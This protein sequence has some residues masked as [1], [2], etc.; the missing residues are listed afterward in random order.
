M[1]GVVEDGVGGR[2]E[3]G[4]GGL[5]GAG[6]VVT[7]EAGEIAA[8]DLKADGVAF[9]ECVGGGPEV[10]GDFVDLIGIDEVG[11]FVGVAVAH[12]EDAVGEIFGEA[13]G[14]DVDEHGGEVGVHG[15]GF[16]IGLE[17]DGAGDLHVGVER[18]GGVDENVVAIF[19]GALISRAG[20][21]VNH[22]AAE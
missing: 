8:A 20:L 21:V 7:V 5:V 19:G 17:S 13:V 11:L 1:I 22:V 18:F 15:G 9:L 14:G 4:A 3:V 6:V 16:Y 10:H 12:A 2:D